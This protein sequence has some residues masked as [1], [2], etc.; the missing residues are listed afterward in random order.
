VR[1]FNRNLPIKFARPVN[2]PDY[3]LTRFRGPFKSTSRTLTFKAVSYCAKDNCTVTKLSRSRD[4][5]ESN[6]LRKRVTTGSSPERRRRPESVA[7]AC[8]RFKR[9]SPEIEAARSNLP[10]MSAGVFWRRTYGRIQR[11]DRFAVTKGVLSIRVE[12][13]RYL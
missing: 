5:A 11:H 2:A 7:F 12:R 1:F 8:P 9:L 6:R 3:I 4:T 10:E 13:R